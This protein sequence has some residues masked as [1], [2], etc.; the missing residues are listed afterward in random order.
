MQRFKYEHDSNGRLVGLIFDNDPSSHESWRQERD[1]N[2]YVISCTYANDPN[3][4]DSWRKERDSDGY[5]ISFT[6]ANDPNN[7]RSWR[8]EFLFC[9]YCHN[10]ILLTDG[11]I[12]V[13]CQ[14]H[15]VDFWR[16]HWEFLAKE[17]GMDI[18]TARL[19]LERLEKIL[20][21]KS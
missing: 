17:D 9:L 21:T 14:V 6:V 7:P 5:V 4:P 10:V 20:K 3:D 19:G 1:S 12:K 8:G 2:G 11:R 18:E 15:S 13:G 16:D